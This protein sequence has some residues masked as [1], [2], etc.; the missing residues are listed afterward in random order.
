M[1][2][3]RALMNL[4]SIAIVV[5]LN[6]GCLW[7]AQFLIRGIQLKQFGTYVVAGLILAIVNF[8]IKPLLVLLT[9]P[10]TVIT[11]GLFIFVINALLL[12]LVAKIV[13]GFYIDRFTSALLAAIVI[14]IC[15]FL[16]T[17]FA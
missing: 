12:M 13:P 3:N 9:L 4:V 7:V 11:L 5:L 10:I 14:A 6:A 16:I 15:N 1:I 17:Y 2:E 8:L